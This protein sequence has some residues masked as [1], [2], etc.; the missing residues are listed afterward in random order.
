MK[1]LFLS[2][3]LAILITTPAWAWTM[4]GGQAAGGLYAG[5]A[6]ADE[7]AP[8]V[9][10]ATIGTDGETVTIAFTET[11]VT[12]GYDNGDFDLDCSAAGNNI[13]LNSISGSG[14]SRTFTA[15]STVNSGD[16]CNL[17]YTGTTDEI[18]DAAGNDLA[19]FSDDSVT[20]NSTQGG[21]CDTL[22]VDNSDTSDGDLDVFG[23]SATNWAAAKFTTTTSFDPCKI[24]LDMLRSNSPGTTMTV[25]IYSDDGGEDK[26]SRP[27]A[28][29]CTVGTY[30]VNNLPTSYGS[31]IEIEVTGSCSTLSATTDYWVVIKNSSTCEAG[32]LVRWSRWNNG[33]D[34]NEIV[35]RSD[36]GG[37][38]WG[39]TLSSSR[40][41][42]FKIYE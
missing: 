21:A 36:D 33:A 12:T 27:N 35:V 5:S 29:V 30:T 32:S 31:P 3:I 1:K 37:S 15:A 14:S 10:S 20:N 38:T 11:V 4:A 42:W 39:T 13:S 34:V 8:E 26:A 19:G 25:E 28:S 24:Q 40:S 16:T 18:E 22:N 2:T 7:T 9:S 17:D 41:A 6:G 23:S